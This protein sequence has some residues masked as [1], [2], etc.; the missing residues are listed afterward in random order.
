MTL[1]NP[2]IQPAPAE[3]AGGEHG[4]CF[5][6]CLQAISTQPSYAPQCGQCNHFDSRGAWGYC[7]KRK[8]LEISDTGAMYLNEIR[9]G[10]DSAETCNL[11]E[12]SIPF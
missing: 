10:N 8:T 4:E 11:Y 5:N 9:R 1:T 3:A 12:Q 6:K 7:S 2:A